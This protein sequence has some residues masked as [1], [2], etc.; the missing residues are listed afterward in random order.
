[1]HFRDLRIAAPAG[2]FPRTA[3]GGRVASYTLS[4]LPPFGSALGGGTCPESSRA[5][6]AAAGL[7]S[8]STDLWLTMAHEIGHSLGAHHTFGARSA[9]E[10]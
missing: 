8:R 6:V 4:Q 10:P 7:S 9:L 1:M 5:C 3:S 2:A